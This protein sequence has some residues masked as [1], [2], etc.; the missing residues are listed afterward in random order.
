MA[1]GSSPDVGSSRIAICAPFI[2]ISASPSRCRMPREKV[3]TRFSANIGEADPLERVGDPLLA[4]GV[5]KAD[6]PRGVAQIVGGGEIVVEA[7]RVGQIADPA[8]DR[9]RLARRI[10]AEHAD[11]A[12]R[13]VG[14]AEQHQDRR[15]L[16]GAVRP[17]QAE[18]LAAP[19]RE[20]DVVDGDG[21]LP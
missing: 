4:F 8:L 14:E 11:L 2:R 9:E 16:A 10:E 6:Q 5:P 21:R 15:R 12:G 20:R 13:D 19:D 3:P 18:D 17:E 7:D 1:C